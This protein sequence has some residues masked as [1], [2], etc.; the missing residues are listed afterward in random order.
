[1]LLQMYSYGSLEKSVQF[2]TLVITV[3]W[4]FPCYISMVMLHFS[5]LISVVTLVTV[6][7]R[8]L[9]LYLVVHIGKFVLCCYTCKFYTVLVHWLNL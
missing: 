1:M 6:L 8:L 9:N 2:I 5:N 3:Q 7:L 4:Y